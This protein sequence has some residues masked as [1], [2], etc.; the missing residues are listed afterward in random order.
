VEDRQADQVDGHQEGQVD[1]HRE[2]RVNEGAYPDCLGAEGYSWCSPVQSTGPDLR[3]W[4]SQT[5]RQR[6]AEGTSSSK[7]SDSNAERNEIDDVLHRMLC[8]PP[9]PH[10]PKTAKRKPKSKPKSKR[11]KKKPA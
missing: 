6:M 1:G 8:T 11:S 7:K 3:P 4:V 9:E 5:S 2:D 10:K